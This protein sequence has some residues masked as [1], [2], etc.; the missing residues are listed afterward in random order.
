MML[1][2][3]RVSGPE[4]YRLGIVEACVPTSDL[5]PTALAMAQRIAGYSPLATQLAKHSLNTIENMS[6]RDGYRYEQNMTLQLAK[7]ED[8]LALLDEHVRHGRKGRASGEGFYEWN[9]EKLAW[10]RQVRLAMLRQR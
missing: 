4:L 3:D 2:G 5:M 8:V 10:L 1:T 6:L 7:S 9:P